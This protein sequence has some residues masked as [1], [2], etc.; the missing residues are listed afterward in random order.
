MSVKETERRFLSLLS[1]YLVSLPSDLKIL[2]EAVTDPDLDRSAREIAAG[3]IVHTLF[4]QEGEG[5]LR[6]V[7]DALLV[8]AALAE[9]RDQGGDGFQAF[10]E[11]F[12]D[13]YQTL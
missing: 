1:D 5:L 4:P 8:R 11:R 13:A 12:S 6:F 7:D 2:Q 10:R 9:I 3:A